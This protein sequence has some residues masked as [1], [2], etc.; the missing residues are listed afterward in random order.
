LGILSK[1]GTIELID[2]K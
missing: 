1:T 2:M